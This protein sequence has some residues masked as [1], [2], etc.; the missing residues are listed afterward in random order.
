MTDTRNKWTEEER[1]LVIQHA[2]DKLAREIADILSN[3][4]YPGRTTK[5]VEG[6]IRRH[7]EKYAGKGPELITDIKI[8]YAAEATNAKA[9]IM[10]FDIETTDLSAEFGEMLCFGYWWHEEP[11]PV[12]LKM[13]DYPGWDK[14]P[15]EKRD[16]YLLQDVVQLLEEADVLV[17]HFSPGFDHPFIQTRCLMHGIKPIPKPIHIDTWRIAK[18]NLRLN[19]NK[20]ATVA[21]ALGGEQ[22]SGVPLHIWRRAKA[23]DV[24]A[25]EMIADYN[26]QD[27]RTQKSVT[28]KL[29]P[30]ATGMPNWNLLIDDDVLHCPACGSTSLQ[31]RGYVYTKLYKYKRLCC[32]DCGKWMR[33]RNSITPKDTPRVTH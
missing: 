1:Q 13:W 25:M 18:K 20:L 2:G 33:D 4:G 30:L 8:P 16:L 11:N 21:R 3:K 17:G 27:V 15:V 28:Q 29:M 19:N 6:V 9:K 31:Y 14:L 22:K 7:K 26:I 12:V 32:N 24:E 5:A 23:H 10:Y